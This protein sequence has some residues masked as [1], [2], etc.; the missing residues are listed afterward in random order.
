M[1]YLYLMCWV[2]FL[3][4]FC[5]FILFAYRPSITNNKCC[6]H[7]L[8]ITLSDV[9]SISLYVYY[10]KKRILFEMKIKFCVNLIYFTHSIFCRV[11]YIVYL[12]SVIMFLLVLLLLFSSISWLYTH[13]E[14][15]NRN[16]WL[17]VREY[18]QSF[19]YTTIF[20]IIGFD[21]N[22]KH[23]FCI[24]FFMLAYRLLPKKMTDSNCNAR[25]FGLFEKK[26][27]NQSNNHKWK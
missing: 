13:F 17:Y 20:F 11:C 14:H 16:L 1:F 7:Q 24:C 5:Y 23:Q 27:E 6:L 3:L 26:T 22:N 19:Y 2:F 9:H 10:R 15:N 21:I 18:S 4:F 12:W 8:I 25:I